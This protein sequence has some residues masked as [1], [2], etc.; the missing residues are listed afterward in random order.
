MPA[1]IALLLL[2]TLAPIGAAGQ[3][4][5]KVASNV[6]EREA[7]LKKKIAA[8]PTDPQAYLDLAQLQED[9]GAVADAE[10]TLLKAQQAVATNADV[11][12]QL[13]VF[14]GRRGQFEKTME[15]LRIASADDP[16]D[17]E[18]QY[19]IAVY[20]WD[21]IYSDNSLGPAQRGSYIGEGIAAVDRALAIEPD[22]MEA[23][24][25][26][27]LLLRMRAELATN[28]A[29]KA[30]EHRRSGR[31]AESRDGAPCCKGAR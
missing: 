28:S 19:T 25:Y 8:A 12:F 4:P 1:V 31:A 15:M 30:R 10:A 5:S 16:K 17:S 11:A 22:Y 9:F 26:K 29:E 13:A 24:V 23:L 20:Y 14:Y 7:S 21:K 18:I 6:A 27:G 3:A 2:A